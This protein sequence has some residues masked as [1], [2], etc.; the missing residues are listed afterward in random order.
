MGNVIDITQELKLKQLTMKLVD[1][2]GMD[3][4]IVEEMGGAIKFAT[5]LLREIDAMPKGAGESIFDDH[6]ELLELLRTRG[7]ESEDA[8]T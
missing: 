1:D 3:Y 4:E 7:K 6:G 2:L 8:R 5:D